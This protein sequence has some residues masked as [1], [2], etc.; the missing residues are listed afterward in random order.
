MLPFQPKK[1]MPNLEAPITDVVLATAGYDHTIRFWEALSGAYIRTIQ[2]PESINQ[3]AI[4]PDKRIL[5]TAG[6][7]QVRLYDI[8]STNPNPISTYEGHTKIVTAVQF[9]SQ[10]RSVELKKMVCDSKRRRNH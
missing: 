9:Q 2:H 3:L 7:L 10:G 1:L 8:N 5:A 6:N 4:S